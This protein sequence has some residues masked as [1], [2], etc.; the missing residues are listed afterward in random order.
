MFQPLKGPN[1]A[2]EEEDSSELLIGGNSATVTESA[3]QA[4]ITKSALKKKPSHI[5]EISAQSSAISLSAS[6]VE[7][8]TVNAKKPKM[9]KSK[10]RDEKSHTS[11]SLR[12]EEKSIDDLHSKVEA[13]GVT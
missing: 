1:S 10:S 11:R 6:K 9:I 13:D 7:K 12:V 8:L 3:L 4:S 5:S 2:V